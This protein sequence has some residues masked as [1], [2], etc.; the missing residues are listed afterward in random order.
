MLALLLGVHGVSVSLGTLLP[1]LGLGLLSHAL[2]AT[3][4]ILLT[5]EPRGGMTSLS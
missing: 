4:V 3:A 2:Q 1:P 5:Q